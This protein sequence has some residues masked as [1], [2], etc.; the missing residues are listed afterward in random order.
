MQLD[1]SGT[2]VS[3]ETA[4]A[5][6]DAKSGRRVCSEYEPELHFPGKTAGATL[7]SMSL[8]DSAAGNAEC[9]IS[10]AGL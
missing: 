2:Q 3:R 9:P 5:W 6:R 1:L 10:G 4:K 7:M 8:D